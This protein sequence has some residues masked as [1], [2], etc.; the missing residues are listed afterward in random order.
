MII[1]QGILITISTTCLACM[2]FYVYMVYSKKSKLLYATK[3]SRWLSLSGKAVIVLAALGF[4]ACVYNGTL[5]M[6]F[7]MPESWGGYDEEGDWTTFS[8]SIAAMVTIFCGLP[9][10]EVIDRATHN[11]FAL[12]RYEIVEAGLKDILRA[13]D[14]EQHLKTLKET[15]EKKVADLELFLEQSSE[16]ILTQGSIQSLDEVKIDAY[17]ELIRR[18]EWQ[19]SEE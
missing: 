10:L 7:W 12:R 5:A 15:Y 19:I 1:F 3:S 18:V 8:S 11:E 2:C 16:S 4:L 13:R 9:M 14:S 17:R 6:I